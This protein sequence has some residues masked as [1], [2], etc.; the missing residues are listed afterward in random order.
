M[1]NQKSKTKI[2]RLRD[3]S[4]NTCR[5]RPQQCS[6]PVQQVAFGLKAGMIWVMKGQITLAL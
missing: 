6:I 1:L 5:V 3:F 4:I 2:E